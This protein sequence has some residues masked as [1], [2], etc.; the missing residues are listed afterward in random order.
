MGV[1]K[2]NFIV[3]PSP[4]LGAALSPA[5]AIL[6]LASNPFDTENAIYLWNTR[7]GELIGICSG[8]TQGIGRL[9][10]SPDGKTLASTSTDNTLRFWNV[11]TQQEL[12]SIQELG[13]SM[14]ENSLFS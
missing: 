14:Q 12:L 11:R 4:S 1:H 6:A 13:N 3:D 7:T 2:T 5:G 10:F 9:A 8:H